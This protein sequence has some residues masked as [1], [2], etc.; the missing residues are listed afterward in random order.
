LLEE[1][2]WSQHTQL[3]VRTP[4]HTA[5]PVCVS[6]YQSRLSL[7]RQRLR[8][9]LPTSLYRSVQN[10]EKP[11]VDEY[12]MIWELAPPTVASVGTLYGHLALMRVIYLLTRNIQCSASE[13]CNPST[14]SCV[15]NLD[16]YKCH[17]PVACEN[18]Q[19]GGGCGACF[20]DTSGQGWCLH[21]N[22]CGPT[23]TTVCTINLDCGSGICIESC[24]GLVYVAPEAN[25]C[26]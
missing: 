6:A 25:M 17:A 21:N 11:T 23:A 15:I 2:A 12:A 5:A 8:L 16:L 3:T 14:G 22:D 10:L 13:I 1:Q 20:P 4:Q 18:T 24:C 9:M 7:R 26:F 19:C